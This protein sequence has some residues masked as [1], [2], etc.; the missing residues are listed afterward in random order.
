MDLTKEKKKLEFVIAAKFFT[1][2]SLNLEVVANTFRPLWRIR[3]NFELSNSGNNVLLIAF[4]LEVDVEKVLQGEPWAFDRHLVAIQ[5]YGGSISIHE[6]HFEKSI[7]YVQIHNLLFSLL[8]IE[9][10]LNIGETLGF[11]TIP[12][13]S[14][15]MKGGSFMKVRVEV[16]ITKPLCRGRKISWDQDYKGWA[17]FK[18]GLKWIPSHES[19]LDFWSDCQSNLGPIRALIQGPLPL[20]VFRPGPFI[21]P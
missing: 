10:I 14:G 9:A 11:V 15:Q 2:R 1:C 5:R 8:T 21:E 19:N 7:F 20:K 18:K 3:G 16:D 6:L 12:K 13:D 4:E 17:T